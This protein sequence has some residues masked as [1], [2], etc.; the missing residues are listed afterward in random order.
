[1]SKYLFAT[2]VLA[3]AFFH[4]LGF[5]RAYSFA[6]AGVPQ[7]SISAQMGLLWLIAAVLFMITAFAYLAGKGWAFVTIPAVVL[8]QIL[9]ITAWQEAKWA[10]II[11]IIILIVL[12][13]AIGRIWFANGSKRAISHLLAQP[14]DTAPIVTDEMITT[15]PL[16]VQKWLRRAGVAG[17]RKIR[18]IQLEQSGTMRT[19]PGAI[20]MPFS[21]KQYFT[22]GHPGFVWMADVSMLPGINLMARDTLINGE[23]GMVIKLLSVF[24]IVNEL[25]NER[26]NTSSMIRF[27]AEICW[28]P[29]AALNQYISWETINDRFAKATMT[30]QGTTVSGIFGFAENGDPVSFE[31]DRYKDTREGAPLVKWVVQ[32]KRYQV[33]D[34]LRVPIRCSITWKLDTGN[35]TWADILIRQ[36]NY[37]GVFG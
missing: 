30:Y 2:I 26:M 7:I 28:F 19:K 4:S 20:W 27:L 34:G 13:P 5:Y 18:Y 11:N 6:Y 21:A 3:H 35:F 10:S 31:A 22:T 36:V 23:G 14:I 25:P 15:L 1:M 9:I 29:T 32:M 8:S 12:I 16:V 33:F 37:D 17:K 24:P